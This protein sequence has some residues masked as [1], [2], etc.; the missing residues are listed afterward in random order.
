M[1]IKDMS[2]EQRN[3]EE[4]ALLIG[5]LVGAVAA[6]LALLPIRE[7]HPF[8]ELFGR[9]I[10]LWIV[11]L[12]AILAISVPGIV[13][14][15]ILPSP[16]EGFRNAEQLKKRCNLTIEHAKPIYGQGANQYVLSGGYTEWPPR[17]TS[18]WLITT[19]VGGREPKYWPQAEIS[20]GGTEREW[21]ARIGLGPAAYEDEKM[22]AILAIV[23]ECGQILCKYYQ[24]TKDKSRLEHNLPLPKLPN[25][26]IPCAE[27]VFTKGQE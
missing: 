12:V 18:V 17:G 19:L 4:K 8:F 20:E 6:V 14:K 13:R 10:P 24:G 26:V 21:H 7:V 9:S 15:R 3:W 23:G 25:D 22:K 2:N 27:R 11:L 16:E 1:R 5:T